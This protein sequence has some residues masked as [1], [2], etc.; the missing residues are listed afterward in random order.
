MYYL[1]NNI[2]DEETDILEQF[3]NCSKC[4]GTCGCFIFLYVY[5]SVFALITI[6]ISSTLQID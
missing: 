4:C 2:N 3:Y 1:Q 5:I 6:Y